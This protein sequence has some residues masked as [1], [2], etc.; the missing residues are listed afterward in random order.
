MRY[1]QLPLQLLRKMAADDRLTENQL[2]KAADELSSY[3]TSISSDF[4][5]F[6]NRL[7][8]YHQL[9]NRQGYLWDWYERL[10]ADRA[11]ERMLWPWHLINSN[12]SER[13]RI[14]QLMQLIAN[15][16]PTDYGDVSLAEA[17]VGDLENN[18]HRWITTSIHFETD[19]GTDPSL[20]GGLTGNSPA[21]RL[22]RDTYSSEKVTS[23][24]LAL[25]QY[26]RRHG[27]FPGTLSGLQ[28]FG[29]ERDHRLQ[30]IWKNVEFGY[31]PNGFGRPIP[32]MTVT[33][34][35]VILSALQPVIWSHG[36]HSPEYRSREV[37]E[38]THV[39]QETQPGRIYYISGTQ[40]ATGFL[41]E[42]RDGVERLR[43]MTT[44]TEAVETG[45]G[46]SGRS[47]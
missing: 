13:Y 11:G 4:N 18:L 27:E 43:R 45:L 6:A 8:V 21:D 23:V 31:A 1:Q 9:L 34:Q 35:V 17:V 37:S 20:E 29:F 2:Q 16:V 26:R 15:R 14:L 47:Q 40:A 24:V 30:D 28:E 39:V 22:F 10:D 36:N 33:G 25:Q 5:V 42:F 38:E 44:K 32:I 7:V 19:L 46:G 41:T 12:S 3:G